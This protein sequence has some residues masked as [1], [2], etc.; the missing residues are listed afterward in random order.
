MHAKVWI[1]SDAQNCSY[2]AKKPILNDIQIAYIQ[3]LFGL[4]VCS[5]FC[6]NSRRKEA[7]DLNDS[8]K[9]LNEISHFEK[10][11]VI[12]LLTSMEET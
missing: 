4:N 9:C 12:L 11:T 1:Q 10:V 8:T 2:L 3:Y 6:P 5:N 7:R